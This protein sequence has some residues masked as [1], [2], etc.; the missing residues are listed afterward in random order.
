MTLLCQ[1]Y[2]NFNE[3][4]FKSFIERNI[5]TY[6]SVASIFID[7][8]SKINSE[9]VPEKLDI[10]TA[11]LREY[12]WQYLCFTP[13]EGIPLY[14]GLIAIQLY[15]AAN[16]HD[17]DIC[18]AAAYNPRLEERLGIVNDYQLH[19]KYRDAQE[20][21]YSDFEQWCIKNNFSI[22][23][24]KNSSSHR[25]VQ[26]PLSLALLHKK[27]IESLGL[28]FH[29]CGLAKDD[30]IDFD[31]FCGIVKSNK[32]CA[33]QGI[34]HKMASFEER[35]NAIIKQ[36]YQIYK[37]WDG[38]YAKEQQRI[39]TNYTL[40]KAMAIE[41]MMVWDIDSGEPPEFW[42]DSEK[43]DDL[44]FLDIGQFFAQ[45]SVNCN[46]WIMTAAKYVSSQGGIKY[47]FVYVHETAFIRELLDNFIHI[48][49]SF[50]SIKIF[51][52]FTEHLSELERLF[53]DK[54]KQEPIIRLVGGVKIA[55]REWMEGAGPI[56]EPCNYSKGTFL[57]SSSKDKESC[58]C[59][60]IADQPL[61]NLPCGSYYLQYDADAPI[62]HFK[63]CVPLPYEEQ[64]VVSGWILTANGFAADNH[65]FH[66]SGLDFSRIPVDLLNEQLTIRMRN[67]GIVREWMC[68]AKGGKTREIDNE[69][70]ILKVLRRNNNGICNR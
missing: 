11:F 61:I 45:D 40:N 65:D 15:A 44:S 47:V 50:R 1:E 59:K 49:R 52:F 48:H 69:H 28:F 36:M 60:N 35:G 2:L 14:L 12:D 63:I 3:W 24:A 57:L 18:S 6:S 55:R 19:A 32:N 5:N 20:K 46:D 68:L 17:D 8:D 56:I 9:I 67:S 25:Y 58:H 38:T 42:V 23:L 53:P 54:F 30:E 22:Y 4:V 33:S 10:V 66:I 70:Y 27:D 41:Y 31:L 39:P 16:R 64:R 13:K 29:K 7:I 21:I 51:T 37:K 43:I 26:Y 34:R 62:L